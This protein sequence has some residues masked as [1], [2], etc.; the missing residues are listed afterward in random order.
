MMSFY[1]KR[2]VILNIDGVNYRCIIVGIIKSEAIKLLE[3]LI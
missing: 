1:I 3:M 2:T